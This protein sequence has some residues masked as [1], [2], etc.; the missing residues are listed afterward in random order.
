MPDLL[1]ER[2]T[3][4]TRMNFAL[5]FHFATGSIE[6]DPLHYVHKMEFD[7]RYLMA[8]TNSFI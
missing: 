8:V 1:D 5:A 2:L 4:K 6:C 7:N 3:N